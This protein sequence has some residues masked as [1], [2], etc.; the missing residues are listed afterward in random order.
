[1]EE[2]EDFRLD[3]IRGE[4]GKKSLMVVL[5]KRRVSRQEMDALFAEGLEVEEF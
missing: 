5:N 1:M 3:E 2:E 4:H